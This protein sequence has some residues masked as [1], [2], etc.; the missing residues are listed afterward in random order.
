MH[1]W[2]KEYKITYLIK[3]IFFTLHIIK[4]VIEIICDTLRQLDTRA[5]LE[6]PGIVINEWFAP[7][8]VPGV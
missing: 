7:L 6:P 4:Y 8:T 3:L 5:T 1:F 2:K